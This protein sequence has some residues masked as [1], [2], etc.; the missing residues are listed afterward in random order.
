[1]ADLF[2]QEKSHTSLR[3][4]YIIAAVVVVSI[5]VFGS[6]IASFYFTSV[7]KEN[8]TLLKLNDNIIVQKVLGGN[9]N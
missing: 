7:T 6:I 1:M 8:T 3:F 4:Q 5:L 2:T 9:K